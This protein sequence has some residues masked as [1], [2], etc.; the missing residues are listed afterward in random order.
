MFKKMLKDITKTPEDIL[1]EERIKIII[2]EIL[3][4]TFKEVL[5]S[6]LKPLET[7]MKEI[8]GEVDKL[9]ELEKRVNN[10]EKILIVNHFNPN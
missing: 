2:A 5:S 7:R 6:E 1:K 8:M 3:R 4:T 10:L 9:G